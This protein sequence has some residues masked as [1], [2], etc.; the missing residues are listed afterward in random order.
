LKSSLFQQTN[1][2]SKIINRQWGALKVDGYL[3]EGNHFMN[4]VKVKELTV[5]AFLPYGRF[6]TLIDPKAEKL[7]APPIEFYR[8]MVQQ[9]MGGSDISFSICRVEKRDPVINTS[10]YHTACTEGILPLDN[11]ALIHVA[12]ASPN[13]ETVPVDRIEVFRVPKGTVAILRPGIW[14]HAP[15]TVNDDPANVLIMLPERTYAND[16]EVYEHT[17]EEKVQIEL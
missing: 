16:C 10:E 11:D 12:P 17:A 9:D 2:Q 8:D 4:R 14:H 1:R 3:S 15:F 6:A 13:G 5:E 7:G